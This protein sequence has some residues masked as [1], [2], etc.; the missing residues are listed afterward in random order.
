MAGKT[1]TRWLDCILAKPLRHLFQTPKR[2]LGAHIKP[3]MTVLDVG[4]GFG[5]YS[6]GM[7]RLAGE[8]GR[9][10]CIDLDARKIE[11]LSQRARQTELSE[12][13]DLRV[14]SDRNLEIDDLA[15]QVDFALA[16]Y[17]V[18]HVAD[19]YSLM[20]DIYQVLRSNGKFYIVE[21]RHHASTKEC[22]AVEAA[23]KQA[24][25]RIAD[26]PRLRRDWAVIFA[27]D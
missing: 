1:L 2:L 13:I 11:S 24:G 4:C 25:F 22:E 7:A 9:V 20:T 14:S 26:Y 10:I 16:V 27:K 23:A 3:G 6:L 18:H 17:V 21:P 5:Y 12:R 8:N 19:T 15:N